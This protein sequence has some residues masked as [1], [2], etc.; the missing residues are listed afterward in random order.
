M[1]PNHWQSADHWQSTD[2]KS[3]WNSTEFGRPD[4]GFQM[5]PD[6]KSSPKDNTMS[7]TKKSIISMDDDGKTKNAIPAAIGM[8][9]AVL[10]AVAFLHGV[11]AWTYIVILLGWWAGVIF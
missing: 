8:L 9:T 3:T 5:Y 2:W 6:S 11:S 1:H 10:F 7:I 4:A